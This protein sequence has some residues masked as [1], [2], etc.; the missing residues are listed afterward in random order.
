MDALTLLL[1][2]LGLGLLVAGAQTLVRG[3]SGLASAMGVSPLVIGLTVVAFGTSAPEIA[4]SV[5]AALQGRADLSIGNVVG[6]NILNVLFILGA[7]ALVSPLLVS[8]SLAHIQVPFMIAVSGAMLVL[9]LDGRIDR[10]DGVLLVAG[11]IAYT[12]FSVHGAT[13]A[14]KAKAKRRS[15]GTDV[16]FILAGLSMLVLGAHWLVAG[17]SAMARALGASELVI[18]LTVVAVGTS[19]PEIATSIV[20]T[21]RGEREIAVGNVVGSNI[22]NILGVLGLSSLAAP[23]GL[24]VSPQV[25]THDLPVMLGVAVVCLPVFL[26]GYVL[27]RGEGAM[28]LGAYLAY[29]AAQVVGMPVKLPAVVLLVAG[30]ILLGIM[31]LLGEPPRA[32]SPGAARSPA[33]RP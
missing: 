11:L 7:A 13:T 3:A 24:P 17:A 1:F 9:A 28:L 4:V 21:M 32:P 33:S 14:P 20:A 10:L 15:I 8:R 6:S 26:S 23:G 12:W 29:T 2:V 27:G 30:A 31:R 22:F 25:L 5:G 16:L 19:L 18:G